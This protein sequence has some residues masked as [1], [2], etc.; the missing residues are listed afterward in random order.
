MQVVPNLRATVEMLPTGQATVF[1][2]VEAD[3]EDNPDKD[4][5]NG[6]SV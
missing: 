3:K 5:P 1:E 6:V 2:T 4:S